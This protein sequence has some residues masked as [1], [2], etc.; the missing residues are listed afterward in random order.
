M[1]FR[2]QI[3]QG[4][5]TAFLHNHMTDFKI[6]KV[7]VDVMLKFNPSSCS[8]FINSFNNVSYV[9]F[10]LLKKSKQNRTLL[11]VKQAPVTT[12][13]NRGRLGTPG[14][15]VPPPPPVFRAWGRAGLPSKD[16]AY[17]QDQ[18]EG[19]RTDGHMVRVGDGLQREGRVALLRFSF[20]HEKQG[21]R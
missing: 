21:G 3:P 1:T 9:F 2:S 16:R 10:F 11:R 20:R 15:G 13:I 8:D 14:C 12:G 5:F 7:N 17:A 18:E 19:G 6:G 4:L